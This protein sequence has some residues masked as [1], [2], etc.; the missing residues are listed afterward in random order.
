MF[1]ADRAHSPH[2]RIPVRRA[3]SALLPLRT[4]DVV[5]RARDVSRAPD[6][7]LYGG[8]ARSGEE[9]G[10]G[11]GSAELEV[12]GAVRADGD[13][14]GDGGPGGVVG[15]AGVEFLTCGLVLE[16]LVA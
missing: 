11:G 5:L 4:L 12:E 1:Q 9:E 3:T 2:R 10:G 6:F 15:G 8:D 13:A 14:G 16:F 7:V